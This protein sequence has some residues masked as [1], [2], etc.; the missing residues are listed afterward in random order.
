MTADRIDRAVEVGLDYLRRVGVA[1]SAH[2]T[3][4]EVRQ[5]Y[6]RMWRQLGDRPIE[7]LLDLPPMTDPLARGTM[8]VLTALVA[9]AWH[10][11]ENLRSLVI[12][13]M[14]NLSLE[15]GNSDASCNAYALLGTVLG[16]CFGDYKAAFRFGQLGLDLVEQRGLDRF[17][18]RV[19]LFFNHVN[20]WTRHVRAGRPT[21]A[22]R[23]RCG[24]ADRRSHLCGL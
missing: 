18:A 17:K 19:Y 14:V 22:A 24:A 5:E 10:S 12:G 15:H 6:E 7:A 1:W 21:R 16:P 4:E 9:P 13:R 23:L 20:A 2:P 11:D 8:D 3:E